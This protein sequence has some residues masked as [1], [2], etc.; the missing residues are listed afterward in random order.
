MLIQASVFS[1]TDYP[2]LTRFDSVDVVLL[3]SANISLLNYQFIAF[4]QC[5]DQKRLQERQ[6]KLLNDADVINQSRLV[7]LQT[8]I[9]TMREIDHEQQAQIEIIETESKKKDRKIKV[10]QFTR[11]IYTAA[12]VVGGVYLGY[13][14]SKFLPVI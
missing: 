6:I 3:D 13:V 2:K 8:S 14:A 12:G 5:V 4:D 1:Q 11:T 10:L 7:N 9:N